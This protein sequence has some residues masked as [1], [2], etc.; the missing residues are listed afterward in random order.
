MNANY[1]VWR[2]VITDHKLSISSECASARYI[3]VSTAHHQGRTG[4]TRHGMSARKSTCDLIEP[5]DTWWIDQSNG[6]CQFKNHTRGS[7]VNISGWMR[8]RVQEHLFWCF[9]EGYGIYDF[10]QLRNVQ[11]TVVCNSNIIHGRWHGGNAPQFCNDKEN[12][13]VRIVASCNT[14]WRLHIVGLCAR[15]LGLL[16]HRYRSDLSLPSL[17]I[18]AITNQCDSRKVA[19][20]T[21]TLKCRKTSNGIRRQQSQTGY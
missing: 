15:Q 14:T 5:T 20:T 16:I 6:H 4:D 21:A 19:L 11:T 17:T 3:S 12:I 18:P 8:T 13:S 2:V 1:R 10:L 7:D 9:R